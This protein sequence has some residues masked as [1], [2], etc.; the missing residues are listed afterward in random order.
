MTGYKPQ[1]PV[2]PVVTIPGYKILEVLGKG[3]MAIVYL[4]IQESI[5]RNVALKILAPDHTDD[6][7]SDR[8]LREARIISQLA[9]PNII[10]I[11]D[12]GVHQGYH[13]MCMEY[14]PGRNLTQARDTLSRKQKVDIIKQIALALDYAG[15]KGY[16]HRDIK[17]ENIMLHEDGR[18]I[19]TDFGIARG[20]DVTH[21]LTQTGKAIGTP[22]FM[23][24]EQTKGLEVDHRSDI[25]SLGVVLFQAIAGYVPFDGPSIVAI[26]VK[27]ISEP[28][29]PLP[30]GMEIFQT[31]INKCMS[32]DP[33][34][35]YQSAQELYQALDEI[36]EAQLDYIEAKARAMRNTSPNHQAK[37]Q[38]E[39][40]SIEILANSNARPAVNNGVP[41]IRATRNS[42]PLDVTNTEEYKKLAR[43]RRRWLL[44]ILL[45]ALGAAGYYQQDRLQRL[46]QGQLQPRLVPY[47]P[48]GWLKS[49]PTSVPTHTARTLPSAVTPPPAIKT[50]PPAPVTTPAK[51]EQTKTAQDVIAEL[52]ANRN[53][54]REHPDDARARQGITDARAWFRRKLDQALANKDVDTAQQL[55]QTLRQHFPLTRQLPVFKR[56]DRRIK[57]I[58]DFNAHMEQARVYMAANAIAKPD[59]ANA[60]EEYLAASRI[61]S[62][63]PSVRAGLKQISDYFYKKAK[64]AESKNK[65]VDAMNAV[66]TGLQ[67]S[68]SDPRLLAL[69]Q[70][71]GNIAKQEQHTKQLLQQADELM[72]KKHIIDPPDNNAYQLYRAVTRISPHNLEAINGLQQVQLWLHSQIQSLYNNKQYLDA[73]KLVERARKEFPDSDIFI[74]LQ[75]KIKKAI[76]ATYPKITQIVF[77][78]TP[79][80]D[81]TVAG[82]LTKLAP[83]QSLYAGFSFSN[84]YQDSTQL[85]AQL[86]DGNDKT[87]YDEQVIEVKGRN[88]EGRFALHLPR[89]G[90]SDGNYSVELYMNKTRILKARLSGLH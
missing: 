86:R 19:L 37:T 64:T 38:V 11:Y 43:R 87:L 78:A 77:S 89:P 32:K 60:L 51:T 81:L 47:L 13:Y 27:H 8:F 15:K 72:R 71:L 36:S 26:G 52:Q 80:T 22:Y 59:G 29:P 61:D 42:I 24:P 57:R 10:T 90:S 5:G 6:S 21:G 34:H 45:L 63:D 68:E 35:R 70:E 84:F 82:N 85:T 12:A 83:G 31:I 76:D 88:G 1:S 65:L 75:N 66:T 49:S 58:A 7:F 54:L 20:Q 67:A 44:L 41:R 4:A 28:I 3:G 62:N 14:I 50:R 73:N 48:A 46:W 30:P 17:P 9:H 16:V 33:A 18:A 2:T 79:V 74:P 56:I 55:L 25:Y 53:R 40:A 39:Q 23:S 69:R